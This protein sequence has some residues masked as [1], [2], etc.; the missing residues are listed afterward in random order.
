[1]ESFFCLLPVPF[2]V[3]LHQSSRRVRICTDNFGFWRPKNLTDLD[4][5]PQHWLSFVTLF[6]SC[7]FRYLMCR[8][9]SSKENCE[10]GKAARLTT[11]FLGLLE[12]LHKS[13]GL[14]CAMCASN[15]SLRDPLFRASDFN[16]VRHPIWYDAVHLDSVLDPHLVC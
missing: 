13:V 1:M 10:E 11:S 14:I 7:D 9:L 16:S 4:P 15:D 6:S 3:H 12:D 2:M 5:D 8:Y